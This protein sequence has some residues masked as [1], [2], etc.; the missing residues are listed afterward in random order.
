MLCRA[1]PIFAYIAALTP[2]VMGCSG[3]AASPPDTADEGEAEASEMQSSHFA[4]LAVAA[5]DSQDPQAASSAA[6]AAPKTGALACVTR[7]AVEGQPLEVVLTFTDCAGPFGLAG[8]SGSVFVTFS[9]NP[10]GTL[11]AL[12]QG[13]G[14]AVGGVPV[15]FSAEAD[16]TVSGTTRNVRWTTLQWVRPGAQ[17]QVVS[18]TSDVTIVVDVASQCRDTSGTAVT[19]VDGRETDSTIDGYRVCLGSDGV[20]QCPLGTIFHVH[21][22]SGRRVQVTFDGTDVATVKSPTASTQEQLACSG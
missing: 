7:A 8:L 20:E 1:A 10:D 14:L 12:H 22:D 16:I 11:H 21:E 5:V 9:Q 4:Y 15:T 6:V 17:G 19:T 13:S 3:P 18:H 2:V